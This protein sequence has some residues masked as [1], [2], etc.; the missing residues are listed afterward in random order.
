MGFRRLSWEALV[1]GLPRVGQPP[2]SRRKVPLLSLRFLNNFASEPYEERWEIGCSHGNALPRPDSCWL[3]SRAPWCRALSRQKGVP[4]T[5]WPH[6]AGFFK[7][8][9]TRGED[10]RGLR[11]ILAALPRIPH[12]RDPACRRQPGPVLDRA[13]AGAGQPRR[14]CEHCARCDSDQLGILR[15]PGE[16]AGLRHIGQSRARRVCGRPAR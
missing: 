9:P 11:R 15:R 3:L 6:D 5:R 8:P 13:P 10:R 14:A 16:L 1:P 2:P 4:G 12:R 7:R